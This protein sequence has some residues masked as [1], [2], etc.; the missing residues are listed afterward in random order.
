MY[1]ITGVESAPN[2][3]APILT[4]DGEP[5]QTRLPVIPPPICPHCQQLLYEEKPLTVRT[6]LLRQLET[7]SSGEPTET[8]A[9]CLKL[10]Q[11]PEVLELE[12]A[13]LERLKAAVKANGFGYRDWVQ[14]LLNE[15]IE[16]AA[17][18]EEQSQ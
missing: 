1:R 18:V 10:L 8:R 17:K 11:A 4:I 9:L 7:H 6:A 3:A 16:T 12:N 2:L 15:Y 13:E 5:I 14:G